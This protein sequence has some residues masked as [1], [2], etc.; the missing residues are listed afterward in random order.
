MKIV[1][2]EHALYRIKKRSVMMQEV[3]DAI[4]QPHLTIKKHGL[5]YFQ[6]EAG[7]GVIEVC[8]EKTESNIKVISVYWM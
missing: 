6:R 7:R 4:K 1:F 2:T 8:C 5:Y 3:V